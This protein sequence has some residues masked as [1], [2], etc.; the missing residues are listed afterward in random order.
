[1]KMKRD[2]KLD[3]EKINDLEHEKFSKNGSF[4]K[5]TRLPLSR[6]TF[7]NNS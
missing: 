2:L 6:T 3:K 4:L 1:M 7:I 5:S